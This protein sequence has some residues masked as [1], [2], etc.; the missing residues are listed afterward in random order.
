MC[1]RTAKIPGKA[2]FELLAVLTVLPLV[3][4]LIE[5]LN[6]L[7]FSLPDTHTHTHTHTSS[8]LKQAAR[9]QHLRTPARRGRSG[10]RLCSHSPRPPFVYLMP[11]CCVEL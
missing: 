3:P 8:P 7:G 4:E 6:Y 11:P 5:C 1:V 9:E 2:M 10:E